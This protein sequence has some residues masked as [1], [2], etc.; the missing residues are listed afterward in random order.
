MNKQKSAILNQDHAP[1]FRP[2]YVV[3]RP[4]NTAIITIIDA[5]E[6]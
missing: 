1:R 6:T 4:I 3:V 5:V 2:L